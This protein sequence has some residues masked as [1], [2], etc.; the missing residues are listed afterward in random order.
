MQR[1]PSVSSTGVNARA[2]NSTSRNGSVLSSTPTLSR[3]RSV[4]LEMDQSFIPFVNDA[5]IGRRSFHKFN[6]AIEEIAEEAIKHFRKMNRHNAEDIEDDET[7][8]SVTSREMGQF[9]LNMANSSKGAAE[10]QAPLSERK[11]K[12]G[13]FQQS[14]MTDDPRAITKIDKRKRHK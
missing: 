12:S 4:P 2:K 3:S 6:A 1:E 10:K 13:Y 9:Y 11:R 14:R 7:G 8:N 5:I